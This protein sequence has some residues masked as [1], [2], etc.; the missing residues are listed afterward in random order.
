MVVECVAPVD[1]RLCFILE[2]T[3]EETLEGARLGL[4]LEGAR[5]VLPL[6]AAGEAAQLGLAWRPGAG[7]EEGSPLV[8]EVGSG[9]SVPVTS[10]A[11][12]SL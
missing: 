9:A 10:T 3:P 4:E 5:E 11:D 2:V 8:V 1:D 7:S 6:A 12:P